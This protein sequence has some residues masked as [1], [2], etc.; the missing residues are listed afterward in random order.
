M[1]FREIALELLEGP[2]PH[3]SGPDEFPT[4]EHMRDCFLAGIERALTAA[5]ERGRKDGLDEAAK[6]AEDH[7][8]WQR[9]CDIIELI[10]A[11]GKREENGK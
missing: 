7:D 6:I 3:M 4:P 11:V 10:R 2:D 8:G 9:T 1:N 5:Y